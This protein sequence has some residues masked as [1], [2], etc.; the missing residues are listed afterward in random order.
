MKTFGNI[1][2]LIFGGLEM[3]IGAFIS[4]IVLC[5]TIIFIPVGLQQFKIGKFFIWPMG[6]EVVKTNPNGFKKFLNFFW[7]I[8]FGWESALIYF[9][10]GIIFCITIIGIPF[11]KQY[12]KMAK[13][14]FTPLGHDFV[15]AN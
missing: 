1:L 15:Q 11:G 14:V 2:W 3:A 4:G 7:A 6:K 8:L 5:I 9:L 12:F 10:V 13:F